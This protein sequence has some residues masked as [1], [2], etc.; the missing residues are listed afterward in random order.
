MNHVGPIPIRKIAPSIF[1][2]CGLRSLTLE[3]D[4]SHVLCEPRL[5]DQC[6]MANVLLFAAPRMVGALAVGLQGAPRNCLSQ[7]GTIQVA[8]TGEETA[9]GT[10]GA[11]AIEP[12]VADEG[13]GGTTANVACFI[14]EDGEARIVGIEPFHDGA[15]AVGDERSSGGPSARMVTR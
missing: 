3:N 10:P 11:V 6:D 14:Q 9:L 4:F 7:V 13:S 12:A 1:L 5:L 2:Y 8:G 15:G